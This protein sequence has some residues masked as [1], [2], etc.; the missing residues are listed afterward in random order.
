MSDDMIIFT[1][2]YDFVSWLIP[3]TLKFPR[4]HRFVVTQRLQQS[5]LDFQE[6]LISANV[7]RGISRQEKL[8][9]ADVALTKVRL[10]LR[11]C[12]RWQWLN[13]G[14]YHHAS[15][16]V[17]ELGKLLGGWLKTISTKT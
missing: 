5:A 17:V 11:L 6:C 8:I 10:Y 4:S 7:A 16:R 15:E 3:L 1:R 9:Q 12:Q 14:Q 2:T 13:Q